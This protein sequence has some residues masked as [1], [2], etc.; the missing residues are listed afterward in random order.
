MVSICLFF[1]FIV[2]SILAILYGLHFFPVISSAVKRMPCVLDYEYSQHLM[3]T[4]T[5]KRFLLLLLIMDMTTENHTKTKVYYIETQ[6]RNISW[7]L[8]S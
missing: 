3:V 1:L 5:T 8:V 6:H 7:S 2:L 4:L